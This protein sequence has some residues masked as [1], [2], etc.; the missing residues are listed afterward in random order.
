MSENHAL[1]AQAGAREWAG[2]ALL[3]LPCL[4]VSMDA[5]VLNLAIPQLTSDLRPTN[6]QLLWIVDS[7]GF[8]VAGSLM[9]MGALGDRVGRRRLLLIG[10]AGFGLASL[11]AAFSTSPTMLIAARALLGVAG[12]T[13]MPSTLALIR[14][15]FS[16]PGQRTTAF[17]IWTASFALGGVLAPLVAGI[18]LRHF[19]WGSV[20]L[21]AVPSI[22]VLLA[23]GR[24]LLPEFK[25]RGAG[26]IDAASAALSLVGVLSAVY[27]LK[28]AAQTGADPIAAAAL[29]I[30]VCLAGAFLRRQRGRANPW[31]DLALF[32]RR[33]FSIPLA[34]NS[35]SF[36]VLYGTQFF[37][38]QYLQLVL[39]LSA[40]RAG[41]WT[42]PSA[43]GYLAGSA[44]VPVAA[45]RV[46]PGWLMSASLALTAIGF[47]LLTQVGPESGLPF[48]VTGSVVFSLGLAPVYV[49]TTEMT[50]AS[51]PPARSG[52]ASGLLETT[53]NLGGALGIALL[54]SLGGALYRNAMTGSW[55]DARL[56]LGGA[57]ATASRLPE[58]L[59][60]E[61]AG[62]ARD[63][64]TVAFCTVELVG[65]GIMAALAV[66]SAVL[67]R[68][69]PR[70]QWSRHGRSPGTPRS[71]R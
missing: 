5:H 6:A 24:V 43:L 68:P 46:R 45:N 48:V 36:F 41:L 16:D 51:T 13:L 25:D 17:G 65:A 33:G 31:I 26:R 3:A 60:G 12:A 63:A 38:A 56:T 32:R 35:L 28:R 55:E 2:L 7:Y 44:L 70:S 18:L 34:A 19:W 1:H 71:R 59:A 62:S 10:A 57:M 40:L 4:L 69:R 61:L 39:G 64:F 14:V 66:L 8:L 54:G 30:G 11:L 49:L 52:A 20:F 53:A 27:G 50:V 15:M 22:V 37:I 58:P 9:T 42:I 23:L 67:L 21:V 47:G 29:A